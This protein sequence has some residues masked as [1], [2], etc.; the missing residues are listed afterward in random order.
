[1]RPIAVVLPLY[2][3]GQVAADLVRRMPPV[4]DNVIVVDD[5][6]TDDGPRLATDA[7]ATVLRHD[8]RR[9]VGARCWVQDR[10]GD[11]RKRQGRSGRD[12]APPGGA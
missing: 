3:E 1:M 4:I 7:G 9:G 12:P 2:N 6:S 8:V 11:G 10:G 5:G